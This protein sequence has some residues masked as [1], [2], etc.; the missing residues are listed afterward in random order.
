MYFCHKIAN[1]EIR[2]AEL[3]NEFLQKVFDAE[4]PEKFEL[5]LDENGWTTAKI[6]KNEIESV[7]IL[8]SLDPS[9]TSMLSS[10]LRF[11][12][13]NMDFLKLSVYETR[14]I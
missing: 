12:R 1:T 11:L 4:Q 3:F 7:D 9:R 2:K 6:K 14:P 13:Q 5:Q 8:N 10:D